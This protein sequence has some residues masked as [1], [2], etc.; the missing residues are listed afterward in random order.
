MANGEYIEKAYELA[1]ANGFSDKIG[2]HLVLT[3]GTPLTEEIKNDGFFCENGK[4]HGRIDRLKKPTEQ[5]LS[6]IRNELVAQIEKLKG[7]GFSVSHADS[8]HHIHTDVF[9][10]KTIEDVLKEYGIN[11]IR[12]H[13]NFGDIKFYKK[14]VKNIYNRKLRKNGF[15][16]TDKMG[17]MEDLSKYPET[18]KRSFCEIMVHPDFEEKGQIV[19]RAG[20]DEKGYPVGQALSDIKKHIKGLELVSYKDL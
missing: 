10:I 20:W 19:D 16:T 2:I 13:R 18:V 7:I 8:H 4:F 17:S 14:I 15:I 11:K 6:E 12:L 9:F 1:C 3:E 5:Q